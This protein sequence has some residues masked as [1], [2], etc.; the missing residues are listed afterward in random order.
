M[1]NLLPWFIH[2]EEVVIVPKQQTEFHTNEESKTYHV[3]IV[4]EQTAE[5]FEDTGKQKSYQIVVLPRHQTI[6]FKETILPVVKQTESMRNLFES[7]KVFYTLDASFLPWNKKEPSFHP[8]ELLESKQKP[9]MTV[10]S[11]LNKRELYV[12]PPFNALFSALVI[13]PFA[14]VS[15]DIESKSLEQLLYASGLFPLDI[16]TIGRGFQEIDVEAAVAKAALVAAERGLSFGFFKENVEPRTFRVVLN[17]NQKTRLS[18][19]VITPVKMIAKR[20]GESFEE[21]DVLIK[22]DDTVFKGY[23]KKAIAQLEK[24]QT[25]LEVKAQLFADDIGSLFELKDAQAA[26]AAALA[27][28]TSA[29]K[30]LEAST[31]KAPYSGKVVSLHIENEE[32]PRVGKELIEIVDDHIL[33]AKLLIPSS[34]LNRVKIG[35]N[36]YIRINETQQIVKGKIVRIGATIDPSS[37][38]VKLQAE[39]DNR[40]GKL[41]PG[42]TGRAILVDSSHD[43]SLEGSS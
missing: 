25:E 27:S 40:D 28:L 1:V 26:V 18:A 33:L 14:S 12:Y 39:I 35:Q 23:Y 41:K 11:P 30:N 17:P 43:R 21:G 24:A 15:K 42:M 38:T 22:L 5:F 8:K 37:A 20:M 31:I 29:E 4:S 9:Y 7:G 32:L 19:Q 36:I 3:V 2:A 13:A 16:V 34:V 10:T 6:L